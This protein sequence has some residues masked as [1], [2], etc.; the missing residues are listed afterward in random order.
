M[1]HS[2]KTHKITLWA[3]RATSFTIQD[4]YDPVSKK[5][6]LALFVGCL[7][8]FYKGKYLLQLQIFIT[9]YTSHITQRKDIRDYN[10]KQYQVFT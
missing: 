2:R 9:I 1:I 3:K 5:P 7:P 10:S 4:V 8:K 6:I